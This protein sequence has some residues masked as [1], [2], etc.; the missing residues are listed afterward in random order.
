MNAFFPQ[1]TNALKNITDMFDLLWPMATAL[2]NLRCNVKGFLAESPKATQEL[3]NQRFASGCDIKSLNFKASII[4]KT[5]ESQKEE[6][7]WILLGWLFTIYEGWLSDLRD[8]V[9][10]NMKEKN[11]QFP[12]SFQ[13]EINKF[14]ATPS[15]ILKKC[16]FPA[17][18]NYKKVSTSRIKN[19]LYCYRVFKEMRNC[20]MHNS[21]IAD[22]KT[23]DAYND[24]ITN[25]KTSRD[26]NV[27]EIP[28]IHP[29]TLGSH[30]TPSFRGVVGFSNVMINLILSI[31]TELIKSNVAEAWFN[32]CIKTSPD[33][34]QIT[35]SK[36]TP[37]A[38]KQMKKLIINCGFHRSIHS[39]VDLLTHIK[40]LPI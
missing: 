14:T 31:D 13:S 21:K 18:S 12:D 32:E 17:Y 15:V 2:W 23:L 8:G 22:K 35:F 28:E 6:I 27:K 20:Y 24:F 9:F 3:L 36:D 40:G 1:T 33:K 11:M 39:P 38:I 19:M 25:I 34:K 16:I 37:R 26:L 4:N 5:W 10:N 7:S 29:I 30:I